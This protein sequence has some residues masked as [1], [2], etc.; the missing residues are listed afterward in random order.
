MAC[1]VTAWS[2]V[3]IRTSIPAARATATASFASARSGSMIPA[4][5][6]NDRPRV[7]AIGSSDIVASSSSATSRAANARTRRPW[8]PIRS[9][10][11][12]IPGPAWSKG[13]CEPLRGPPAWLQ[14]AMTTSGAPLTSSMT[15]SAPSSVTRWNVAMN[16]YSESNG[17]SDSRGYA[18]RVSSASTPSFAA[19]T[20]SAASVGSP[21]TD[22]S[23]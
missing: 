5:P 9:L 6:T 7:N 1:A 13:T 20:T 18:R 19:S 2:P 11:S 16:L 10:A 22:P 12:V 4:I 8:R 14:R 21:I 17:T 15:C 3:I 23:S